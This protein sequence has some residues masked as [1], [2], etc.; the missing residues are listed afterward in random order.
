MPAVAIEITRF[1]LVSSYTSHSSRYGWARSAA[2]AVKR[3]ASCVPSQH[4]YIDFWKMPDVA[5]REI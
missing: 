2:S 4:G 5:E 3:S 1:M